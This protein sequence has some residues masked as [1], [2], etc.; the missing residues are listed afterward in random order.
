MPSKVVSADAE[1]DVVSV[2][3]SVRASVALAFD[4]S[5]VF[6]ALAVPAVTV[7]V[8][9]PVVRPASVFAFAALIVA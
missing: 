2:M 5:A 9:V 8:T 1:T 6:K 3:L 7:A 4:N